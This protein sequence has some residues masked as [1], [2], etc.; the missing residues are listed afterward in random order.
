[1]MIVVAIIVDI[2]G[3]IPTSVPTL[4]GRISRI[5]GKVQSLEIR[6][7]SKMFR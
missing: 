4:G 2:W 7:I 5:K 6:T 3:T 1:M